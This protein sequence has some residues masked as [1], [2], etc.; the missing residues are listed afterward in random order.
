MNAVTITALSMAFGVSAWMAYLMLKGFRAKMRK[1]KVSVST[2]KVKGRA[3]LRDKRFGS[4]KVIGYEPI[5]I[6]LTQAAIS[7]LTWDGH[8]IKIP[9]FANEIEPENTIQA[10]AGASTPIWSVK[11]ADS[12]DAPSNISD[13]EEME[14][15]QENIEMKKEQIATRA[16]TRIAVNEA[17]NFPDKLDELI[18]EVTKKPQHESMRFVK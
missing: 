8:V 3:I 9:Y 5:G 12:P 2:P 1:G 6:G 17:V 7:L 13:I 14:M 4:A 10:V 15:E 11:G 18:K 16:K